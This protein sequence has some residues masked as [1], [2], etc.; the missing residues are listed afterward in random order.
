[1]GRLA[2]DHR[3]VSDTA[4]LAAELEA[5]L[6]DPAPGIGDDLGGPVAYLCAEFALQESLPVYSGGLGVLAGD[7]CKTASDARLPMVAVAPYYHRG[8]FR[9]RIDAEGRQEHLEPDVDPADIP[10]RRAAD[11]SGEPLEVGVE[12][13]DRTI[14]LAVW[15]AQVGRVP[16]LLLDADVPGNAPDDRRVTDQL[17]V[18]ERPT[19]L[20]QEL[21]LGVGAARALEA[22]AIRPA[23]W[24][25]NEGHSALV[26]FER[27]RVIQAPSRGS[28]GWP[29][30]D[31]RDATWP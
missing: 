16:L 20:V 1:M 11:R 26:L 15:V 2:A 13:G 28:T 9:Q 24:H 18:A 10:V 25:L 6:D 31:G 27:A 3:F 14:R 7:V 29:R 12:L 19:R 5:Y 30:C 23:V 22:F 21:L 4:S 17:Y 8:Y